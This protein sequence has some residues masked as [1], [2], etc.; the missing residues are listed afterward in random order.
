MTNKQYENI[1]CSEGYYEIYYLNNHVHGVLLI[2]KE[3]YHMF[4]KKI[5]KRFKDVQIIKL[6][7]RKN[8]D[9]E[10]INEQGR[11]VYKSF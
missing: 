11:I 9:V 4:E 6:V 3:M 1:I 7:E 8:E 5:I 2:K 10:S